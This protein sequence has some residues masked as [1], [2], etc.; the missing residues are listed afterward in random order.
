MLLSKFTNDAD[1]LDAFGEAFFTKTRA[2]CV[3]KTGE[4]GG[5]T[6]ALN[7]KFVGYVNLKKLL[8]RFVDT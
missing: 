8:R 1:A 2:A 6:K 5:P 3:H 7:C 4:E